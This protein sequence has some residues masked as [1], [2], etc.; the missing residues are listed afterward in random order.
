MEEK[1]KICCVAGHR[2][3]GFP[4]EYTTDPS[5]L[6]GSSYDT[7]VEEKVRK[8]IMDEGFNY[9]IS[10]GTIGVDLDFAKKVLWFRD[11]YSPHIKLEIA[12]PCPNQQKFWS[13]EDKER[14][15]EIIELADVV[16]L[17]S[18]TYTPSCFHK[19]NE[20]MV[21]KSDMV[22]IF[23]NEEIESGGTYY[24]YE[25]AQKK[26]KDVRCVLLREFLRTIEEDDEPYDNWCETH[27]N[28]I[29]QYFREIG[30][31]TSKEI[32]DNKLR[33]KI[34]L[35]KHIQAMEEG[36]KRREAHRV[37]GRKV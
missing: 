25:Y 27:R 26:G 32:P 2:P 9:F 29:K 13:E 19:R 34:R 22:L 8:A 20:Y 16:T 14:Y 18:E 33:R 28:F 24:T 30:L 21:D 12:V 6:I 3:N 23:R 1:Y 31:P 35:E 4:W 11:F 5:K 10:G 7:L 37:K 36:K 15:Q 17:I